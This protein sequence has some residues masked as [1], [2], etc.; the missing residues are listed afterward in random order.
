MRHRFTPLS[1]LLSPYLFTIL[2]PLFWAGNAIAGRAVVGAVSPITLAFIRWCL[3]FL[4]LLPFGWPRLRGCAEIIRKRFGLLATLSILSV[5][6]YNTLLYVALTTTTAINATLVG[7]V[8]P[9]IIAL[10]SWLIL[11][12]RLSLRKLAGILLSLIGVLF[13]VCRGDLA[14]LL[15]L[16]MHRGDL[17]MMAATLSWSLYSVLLRRYPTGLDPVALLTI[18]V[19]LGIAFLAPFALWE[20]LDGGL[21]IWSKPALVSLAYVSIFPSLIA[22]YFWDR[23]IARLGPT[24]AGLYTYLLPVFTALMAVA[25]LGESFRWFHSTGA[26]LII[27][28]IC[29]TSLKAR[30]TP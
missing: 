29:L 23:G 6:A 1:F 22:Y 5:S 28:G 18:Q 7:S 27:A 9:M 24:V 20:R 2:P 13:V 14:T 19:A 3:A 11:R 4:L 12:E 8:M 30:A 16:E 10:L 21:L 17:I 26:A 25:L 15:G